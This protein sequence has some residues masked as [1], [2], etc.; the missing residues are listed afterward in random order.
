MIFRWT[1][2]FFPN[3][4]YRILFL[5][6]YTGIRALLFTGIQ[7]KALSP[8]GWMGW[9]FRLRIIKQLLTILFQKMQCKQL[10]WRSWS[11][12][13]DVE[14]GVYSRAACLKTL[15]LARNSVL[16]PNYAMP[17]NRWIRYTHLVPSEGN[18]DLTVLASK[19]FRRGLGIEFELHPAFSRPQ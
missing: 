16:K 5:A 18:R 6:L 10:V 3:S 12:F 19:Q 15:A 17:W 13:L 7:M 4:Q 1:A 9:M 14:L 11:E 8:F 2:T